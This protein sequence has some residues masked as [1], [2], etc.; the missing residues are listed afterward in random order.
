M[1]VD[2][3]LKATQCSNFLTKEVIINSRQACLEL[4]KDELDL[5]INCLSQVTNMFILD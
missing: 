4:T 5:V 2:V 1:D 3:K